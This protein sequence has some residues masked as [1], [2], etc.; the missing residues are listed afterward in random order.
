MFNKYFIDPI[1]NHYLDFGGKATRTQYWAFVGWNIVVNLAFTL[2]TTLGGQV[3][4]FLATLVT[5]VFVVFSLAIILPS[6][7]I[8]AR[9]LRDGG[10]S[11][12]L[13]L[14]ALIPFL[15]SLILLVLFLLPSKN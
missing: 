1:K 9:R 3:A 8:G 12:W 5:L 4:D 2:A 6:L 11:P 13:L 15:G 10:F 7:A 14:L